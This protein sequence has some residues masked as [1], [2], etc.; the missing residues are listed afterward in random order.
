[1]QIELL[2]EFVVLSVTKNFSEAAI[3]L[4]MTQPTLSR[5]MS[6]LEKELGFSLLNRTRPLTLTP[7]G[8]NFLP[9]A[10]EI[11]G[12]YNNI[13]NFARSVKGE[14]HSEINVQDLSFSA[15]AHSLLSKTESEMIAIHGDIVFR[16]VDPKTGKSLTSLLEEGVLDIGF[17]QGFSDSSLTIMPIV[18]EGIELFEI[19]ALKRNLSF[20]GKKSNPLLAGNSKDLR[21]YANMKFLSPT[22]RY[23]DVFRDS[24]VRFCEACGGFTPTFDFRE[25]DV[26]CSFYAQDPGQSVFIVANYDDAIDPMLPDWLTQETKK[27]VFDT[28]TINTYAICIEDALNEK[29]REFISEITQPSALMTSR[30]SAPSL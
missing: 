14:T 20:I 2:Q 27:I 28:Y 8:R 11:V 18:G 25:T 15:R 7:N 19:P 13:M 5:H 29:T 10:T 22:E 4:N 12:A 26:H 16:H 23:L 17:V 21:Q 3:Q 6:V 9:Y 1:M 30:F 24:F